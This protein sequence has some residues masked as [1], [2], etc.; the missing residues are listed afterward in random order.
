MIMVG[1]RFVTGHL[2]IDVSLQMAPRSEQMIIDEKMMADE[3]VVDDGMTKGEEMTKLM[4]KII[5]VV[6]SF[7]SITRL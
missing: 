6:T 7:T 2:Q 5:V 1:F 4:T 3:M